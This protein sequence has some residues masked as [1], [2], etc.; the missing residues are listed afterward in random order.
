MKSTYIHFVQNIFGLLEEKGKTDDT[1]GS[2][3]SVILSN[4]ADA[5]ARK[6]YATVDSIRAQVKR[7]GLVIKDSKTGIS[8]DYEE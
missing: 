6:D 5:K 8:W 4:Y 3:M 1:L 2:L 7:E